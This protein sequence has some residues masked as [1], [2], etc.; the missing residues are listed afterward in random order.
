MSLRG[1]CALSEL[2][3]GFLAQRRR[4]ARDEALQC[5][6]LAT[7]LRRV[8]AALPLLGAD[9][10]IGHGL[11]AVPTSCDAFAQPPTPFGM[12]CAARSAD[13]AS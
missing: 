12:W 6:D 2:R 13:D 1:L 9:L 10:A 4:R 3:G 8:L 5:D 11:P 7:L